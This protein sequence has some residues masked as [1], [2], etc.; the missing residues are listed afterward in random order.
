MNDGNVTVGDTGKPVEYAVAAKLAEKKL[1]LS[2]AESLTGGMVA[3][4]LVNVPGISENFREGIVAYAN[5]AKISRLGVKESTLSLF[6]AVSCET[7]EEMALGLIKEGADVAVSTTGIAGPTG[8][9]ADKPVGLVWFGFAT[10]DK[11]FSKKQIFTGNRK[12][13]REKS[14]NYSLFNLLLLLGEIK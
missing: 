1:T 8:G 5:A 7:A 3:A 13:I 9:C 12:E 4:R 6:G 11:V 10:K 2:V 14:T